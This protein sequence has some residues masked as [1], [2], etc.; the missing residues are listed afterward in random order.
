[1]FFKISLTTFHEN[2]IVLTVFTRWH[3]KPCI[4]IVKFQIHDQAY[5]VEWVC[6]HMCVYVHIIVFVHLY[7]CITGVKKSLN[8][9]LSPEQ[10]KSDFYLPCCQITCPKYIFK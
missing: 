9:H 10:V 1:M 6:M 8:F 5:I 4:L 7:V 3:N 2:S